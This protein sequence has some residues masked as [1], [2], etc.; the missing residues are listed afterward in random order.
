[1]PTNAI[2]LNVLPF[3]LMCAPLCTT[4]A[5]ASSLLP[6]G[7]VAVGG[8]ALFQV[9]RASALRIACCNRIEEILLL[10]SHEI[11]SDIA[12]RQISNPAQAVTF[13]RSFSMRSLRCGTCSLLKHARKGGGVTFIKQRPMNEQTSSTNR[14]GP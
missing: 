12:M 14:G 1:M 7:K 10:G 2:S 4:G 11:S 8:G 9:S 5:A 6:S 3:L 13:P